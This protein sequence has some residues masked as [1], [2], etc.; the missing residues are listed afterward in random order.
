MY[1][2]HT[3]SLYSSDGHSSID[4]MVEKAISLGLKDIAVTDHYDPDFCNPAYDYVLDF[5]NYQQAL[6]D[7]EDKYGSQIN[8]IKG[9]ELGLQ[10]G[11]TIKKCI[12][13]V[14]GFSYDF[15]LGA[16]HCAE[17]FD[18]YEPVYFKG[19]SVEKTYRAYYTYMLECLEQ[20]KNYD[21]MAH[22]NIID[23]YAPRIPA[24][25]TYSD[26]TAEIM[27]LLVKDGKGI[28]INTSS[29]RY[30]MGGLC[31]PTQDM[32]NLYVNSG[33]EIITVGSDA[34]RVADV[35][36]AYDLAVEMVRQTGLTHIATFKNRR[37]ELARI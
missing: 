12:K 3:H 28:E 13:A 14:S 32:L 25:N 30:G 6:L 4:G 2:Y 27:T 19:R 35:G 1:D 9:I 37:A 11:A 17:G 10:H 26:I 15:V 8:I 29:K 18:I 36:Y 24:F 33:G 5:E 21:V 20:Y 34:H 22:F 23:R 31:T 7:A 16:F